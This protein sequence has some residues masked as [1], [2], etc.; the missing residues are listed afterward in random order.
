MAKAD[1]FIEIK[2]NIKGNKAKF[3]TNAKREKLSDLISTFLSCQVGAGVDKSE[4]NKLDSYRIRLELDLSD[5]S[6]ICSHNCGNKG[7]RDGILYACVS[8]LDEEAEEAK[9]SSVPV[10]P[11]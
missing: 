2:F 10:T 9:C 7:L 4:P 3:N 11:T 1:I 8:Q 5:D 6:F